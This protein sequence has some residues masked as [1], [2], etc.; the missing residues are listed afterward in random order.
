[1]YKFHLEL[2]KLMLFMFS[3]AKVILRTLSIIVLKRF[4][5]EYKYRLQEKV[6][7][8]PKKPLFVG[9]PYFGPLSLQTGAKFR[10]SLQDIL[11]RCKLQIVL[12][13][14]EK[15]A[16]AFCFKDCIPKELTSGV[17]YKFDGV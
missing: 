5:I 9:L 4:W 17:V 3:R 7:T 16:K 15:L 10:K 2:F 12:K 1:M 14:Q 6:I 13:S 8:V 11:N